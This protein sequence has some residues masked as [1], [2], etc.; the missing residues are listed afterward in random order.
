MKKIV[1]ILIVLSLS[2]SGCLNDETTAAHIEISDL[3]SEMTDTILYATTTKPVI[4]DATEFITQ[5][6]SNCPLDYVWSV[7]RIQSWNDYDKFHEVDSMVVISRE[8]KL[9][10]IFTTI[11]KRLL[12]RLQVTNQYTAH[13]QYWVVNVTSGFDQGIVLFSKNEEGKGMFSILNSPKGIDTLLVMKSDDFLYVTSENDPKLDEDIVDFVFYSGNKGYPDY[14]VQIAHILSKKNKEA[15]AL[16]QYSF[17]TIPQ[18][19]FRFSKTPLCLTMHWHTGNT[20]ELYDLFAFTEDGDVL[21]Y[22]KKFKGE[23]SPMAFDT[24]KHWDRCGFGQSRMSENSKQC[25]DILWL[26]NDSTSTIYGMWAH[27]M[28]KSTSP[29]ASR[30][31]ND[32]IGPKSFP[33]EEI[34]NAAYGLGYRFGMGAPTMNDVFVYTRSKENPRQIYMHTWFSVGWGSNFINDFQYNNYVRPEL[35]E[36]EEIALQKDSRILM[37]P[38]RNAKYFHNGKKVFSMTGIAYPPLSSKPHSREV[39]DAAVATGQPNAEVTDINFYVAKN[40]NKQYVLIALYNPDSD[41]DK[42]GSVYVVAADDLSNI[43]AKYENVAYKP[44]R[45]FYKYHEL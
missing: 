4:L 35:A 6:D 2:L 33:G 25:G 41:V 19:V 40:S 36:G 31:L 34:I 1:Y 20:R 5:T 9:N 39:F 44:L 16:D 14:N 38:E 28:Q 32:Y 24:V 22:C 27:D 11:D 37:L 43:V 15:Y 18:G 45:I 42:K 23:Y 26:Y 17:Q 10:H 21:S 29:V 12:L 8:A 13:I 7:G 30:R 3:S